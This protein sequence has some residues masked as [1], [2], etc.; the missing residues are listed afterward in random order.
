MTGSAETVLLIVGTTVCK[1]TTLNRNTRVC[2]FVTFARLCTWDL[3]N[4]FPCPG[5]LVSC[6]VWGCV[7]S[8]SGSMSSGSLW[9][10]HGPRGCT[11]AWWAALWVWRSSPAHPCW[12]TAA[13]CVCHFSFDASLSFSSISGLEVCH[14]LH[15]CQ[16]F[17]F[18]FYCIVCVQSLPL[19]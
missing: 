13:P 1:C 14:S 19:M 15:P 5:P 9:Q 17:L 6:A 12:H 4:I 18:Y 10:L 7:V 8:E 11:T 2:W 3:V 16:V